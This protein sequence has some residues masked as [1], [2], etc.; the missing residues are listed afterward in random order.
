[1]FGDGGRE[2][3]DLV[4]VGV[5]PPTAF[6]RTTGDVLGEARHRAARGLQHDAVL[7]YERECLSRGHAST[8]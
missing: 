8:S 3:K 2:R 5:R 7:C 4:S 6:D 1:M